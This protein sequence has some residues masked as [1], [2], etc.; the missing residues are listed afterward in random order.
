MK[1]IFMDW[2]DANQLKH[3]PFFLDGRATKRGGVGGG[4]RRHLLL[5]PSAGKYMS[6]FFK[7][8]QKA[9]ELVENAGFL[10]ERHV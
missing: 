7:K 4:V 2:K 8:K 10:K 9:N 6:M 1:S 5:F 3:M